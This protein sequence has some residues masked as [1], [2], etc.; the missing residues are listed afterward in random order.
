GGGEGVVGLAWAFFAAGTP[1]T[2]VSLWPLESGSATTLTL[3][4]HQRLRAALLRGH[5]S[6]ADSLRAA[7]LELRRDPR[8]R[9][10][11]YWAGLVTVGDGF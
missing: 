9:H 2:V 6:V 10:P 8:Y 3:G 11:F 5:A 7:A 1:A 4:L